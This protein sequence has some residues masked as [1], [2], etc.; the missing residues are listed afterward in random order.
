ML[1]SI[2]YHVIQVFLQVATTVLQ[3][4]VH[5]SFQFPFSAAAGFHGEVDDPCGPVHDGP[6]R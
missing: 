4:W 6:T 3:C 1:N 2:L 5:V